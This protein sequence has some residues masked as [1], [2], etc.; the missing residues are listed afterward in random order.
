MLLIGYSVN[1]CGYMWLTLLF[2]LGFILAMCFR[3]KR[4]F[5]VWMF[6]VVVFVFG[7]FI[8]F[9]MLYGY[10]IVVM[11]LFLL[12]L[13]G[14]CKVLFVE[15]LVILVVVVLV[16]VFFYILVVV[17]CTLE[18]IVVNLFVW[19]FFFLIWVIYFL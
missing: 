17:C 11:W 19:P 12:V 18:N 3:E 15:L 7:F 1:V 16:F 9:V 4:N 13:L 10:V 6:F 5:V 14:W 2:F 8:I